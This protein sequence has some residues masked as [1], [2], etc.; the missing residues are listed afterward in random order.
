MKSVD[1]NVQ[2]L[3]NIQ[4]SRESREDVEDV[5]PAPVSS[6]EE[7]ADLCTKLADKFLKNKLARIRACLKTH[8]KAKI[9]EVE[10]EIREALKHAPKSKGG[11]RYKEPEPKRRH[12]SIQ[13]SSDSDD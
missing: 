7:L 6:S 13:D 3:L 5:L 4:Q 12:T 2:M 9:S 1:E 11:S 10:T 8:A